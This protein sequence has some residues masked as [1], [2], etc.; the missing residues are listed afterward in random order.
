MDNELSKE[1]I[2]NVSNGA[3]VLY[4]ILRTHKIASDSHCCYP[5]LKLLAKECNTSTRTVSRYLKE[6][7]EKG[8]IIT[9]TGT[10]GNNNNYYFPKE[11]FFKKEDVAEVSK[12]D[13]R[14][15]IEDKTTFGN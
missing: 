5:S 15:K 4:F 8:Y 12:R 1:I 2:L 14:I 7:E 10:Q 13:G 9:N 6:L 11:S 3:F